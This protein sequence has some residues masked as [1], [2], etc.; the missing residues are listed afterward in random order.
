MLPRCSFL[1][2]VLTCS[3]LHYNINYHYSNGG[4]INCTHAQPGDARQPRKKDQLYDV[5]KIYKICN[6]LFVSI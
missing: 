3:D 1:S 5:D 6:H 2:C 4:E